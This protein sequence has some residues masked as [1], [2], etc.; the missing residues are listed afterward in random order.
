M[1][2]FVVHDSYDDGRSVTTC[3]MF[4]PVRLEEFREIAKLLELYPHLAGSDASLIPVMLTKYIQQKPQVSVLKNDS[5]IE[6][7][8]AELG[9]NAGGNNPLESDFVNETRKIE[10]VIRDLSITKHII[11]QQVR[12]LR[13]LDL[14]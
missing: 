14:V 4:G 11:T 1:V 13:R 2:V 6:T 12:T 7:I 5:S 8:V 10:A 9:Y 3:V